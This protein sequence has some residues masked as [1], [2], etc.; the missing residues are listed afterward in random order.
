MT[1]INTETNPA[2]DCAL[3]NWVLV[4][5]GVAGQHAIT[6]KGVTYLPM[7]NPTD[8]S[9]ENTERYQ[10]YLKRAVYYNT[11][12]RTLAGMIGVAFRTP[13]KTDIPASIDYINDNADGGGLSLDQQAQWVLSEVI[14]KG[15]CGMLVDYP[16]TEGNTSRADVLRG[17]RATI[18]VYSAESIID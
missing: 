6:K 14:K 18:K 1:L 15:R 12:F 5:D 17:I 16:V 4:E 2:Y 3:K 11:C 13:P 8:D 10:Q 7:P 9:T